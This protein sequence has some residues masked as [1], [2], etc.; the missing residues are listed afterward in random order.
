M[1]R[2]AKLTLM[3]FALITLVIA[4]AEAGGPKVSI[5]HKGQVI[6]VSVSALPAH[7]LHGDTLVC[8]PPYCA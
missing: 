6:S 8:T 5:I 1:K 4:V 2:F 3:V 7:L